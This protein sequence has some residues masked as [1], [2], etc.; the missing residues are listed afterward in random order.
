MA[1]QPPR[2]LALVLG[3]WLIL[4]LAESAPHFVH[5]AF[6]VD[7]TPECEYVAT[8]D[9]APAAVTEVPP[10]LAAGRVPTDLVPTP[11]AERPVGLAV[12]HAASRAPPPA[13][14]T[15]T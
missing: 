15:R 2:L 3:A 11:T 10:D 8:A 14:L 1:A 5:H 9:H 6:D 7:P 4:L 12:R 13:P